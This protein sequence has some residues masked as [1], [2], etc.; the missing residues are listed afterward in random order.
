MKKI[1]AFLLVLLFNIPNLVGNELDL[2]SIPNDEKWTKSYEKDG[3][4]VLVAKLSDSNLWAFRAKGIIKA[5]IYGLMTV[6]R[7]VENSNKWSPRLIIKKTIEDKSDVEATTYQVH[8]LPWPASNRDLVLKN[9][10][11][12]DREKMFLKILSYS[13]ERKSHPVT[14]KNVRGQMKFGVIAVRPL[15]NNRVFMDIKFHFDPKGYLPALLVNPIQKRWPYNFLKG[16]EK[17]SREV[18]PN[19]RPGVMKMYNELLNLLSEK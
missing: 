15:K 11:F 6:L 14:S 8:N 13:V 16:L 17:R 1:I 12:L 5:P 18:T 10:L 2:N 9:K 19:V 4:E 7:D 3:I